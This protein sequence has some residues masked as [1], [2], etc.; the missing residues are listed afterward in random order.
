MRLLIQSQTSGKFLAPNL[1]DGQP[2][3]VASLKEAGGGVVF[4]VESAH[5]LVEDWC[6]SDDFPQLIDLDRLGT[7]SD[8]LP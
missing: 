6:E 8:Y 3:W 4:D 2:E 1:D 7:A 5:Q